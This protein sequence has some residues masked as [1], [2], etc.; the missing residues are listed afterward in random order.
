MV[1]DRACCRRPA[2]VLASLGLLLAAGCVERRYTIR[3]EPPGALVVI[4]GEEV[5]TTPVSKS[6]TYY[7]D[8]DVVLVLPNY[9]TQRFVQPIKA[10]WWDNPLSEFFTEN[11]IPLSLR[12][13]QEFT[14]KMTPL[15]LPPTNDFVARGD[16]LRALGQTPPKPR[17]TGILGWLGF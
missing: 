11:L 2:A 17:R 7:G 6:F 9:Q 10:P 12:D 3:T 16:T 15:V 1:G 4:N 5:G 13:E 8:R 14:Y